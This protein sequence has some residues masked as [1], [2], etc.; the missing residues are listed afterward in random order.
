MEQ[1]I[2]RL[3]EHKAKLSVVVGHQGRTGVLLR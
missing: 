2:A 3:P 1:M